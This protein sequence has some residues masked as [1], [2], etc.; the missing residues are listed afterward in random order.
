MARNSRSRY[1]SPEHWRTKDGKDIPISQMSTGH[2][3]NAMRFIETQTKN[4]MD[5]MARL[6]CLDD[7]DIR[8]EKLPIQFQ[9][10]LGS[11]HYRNMMIEMGRR[12][13]Y[14]P[15]AMALPSDLQW[16]RD[17][18]KTWKDRAVVGIPDICACL[19][20]EGNL[21]YTWVMRGVMIMV[22]IEGVQDSIATLCDPSVLSRTLYMSLRGDDSDAE[23]VKFRDL[24]TFCGPMPRIETKC[25]LCN[26]VKKVECPRCQGSGFESKIVYRGLKRQTCSLCLGS[27]ILECERCKTSL[28]VKPKNTKFV[29]IGEVI[30]DSGPLAWALGHLGGDDIMLV[31]GSTEDNTDSV[32]ATTWIDAPDWR[33]IIRDTGEHK[34]GPW[35]REWGQQDAKASTLDAPALGAKRRILFIDQKEG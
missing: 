4:H 25:R 14:T 30:T 23:S 35:V 11:E 29:K 5:A 28:Y 17:G 22:K 7:F 12:R 20:E 6:G 27:R 1:T 3:S 9:A 2:L 16:M 8:I 10:L 34:D 21:H 24:K 32:R 33:I 19:S 18:M 15:N 26:G 31:F 13:G